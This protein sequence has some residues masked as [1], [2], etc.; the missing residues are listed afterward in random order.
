MVE[1]RNLLQ[2]IVGLAGYRG[3]QFLGF[4]RERVKGLRGG[5]LCKEDEGGG[6]SKAARL[7]CSGP[8]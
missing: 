3:N 2:A 5:R 8:S 6:N 4:V 1:R 7:Q